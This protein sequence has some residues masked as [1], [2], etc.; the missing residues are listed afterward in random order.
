MTK[1]NRMPNFFEKIVLIVGVSM[2]IFG[3]LVINRQIEANGFGFQAVQTVFLWLIVIVM[4]II[5][6]ANENMKEE[7]IFMSKQQLEQ[8]KLLHQSVKQDL[9]YED[10]E[11]G[12]LR[13]FIQKE[14]GKNPKKK[15]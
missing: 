14:M 13:R 7:L 11:L 5:L 2:L 4:L 10:Q 1:M 15:K 8:T 12:I 3:Y 6:A 9:A